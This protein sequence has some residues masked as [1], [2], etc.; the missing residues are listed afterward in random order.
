MM[1]GLIHTSPKTILL[2]GAVFPS[3]LT[4]LTF[5]PALLYNEADL[6]FMVAARMHF[7]HCR[8]GERRA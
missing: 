4:L 6:H 3:R 2:F 8:G 5:H 7:R 1:H